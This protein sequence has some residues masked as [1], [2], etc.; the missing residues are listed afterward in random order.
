MPKYGEVLSKLIEK[1]EREK[2]P[3][4]PSYEDDTFIVALDGGYTFQIGKDLFGAFKFLMKDKSDGKI[5]EIVANDRGPNDD[6]Y[7]EDD[8]YYSDLRRLYEGARV[9]ALDVNK[10]LDDVAALLDRF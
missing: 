8:D 4:K 10:K 1:T 3:W 6:D 7:D 5:I 9:T 2:V